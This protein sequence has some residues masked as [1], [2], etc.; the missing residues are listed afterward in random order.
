MPA[1]INLNSKIQSLGTRLGIPV[2][3]YFDMLKD[4]PN[5]QSDGVHMKRSGYLYMDL[6]LLKLR[7]AHSPDC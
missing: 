4:H 6:A 1:V 7:A 3:D 2:V 5:A